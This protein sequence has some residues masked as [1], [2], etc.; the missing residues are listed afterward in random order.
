MKIY[1]AQFLVLIVFGTAAA[2]V[3]G[4]ESVDSI[5][6]GLGGL[7]PMAHCNAAVYLIEYEHS[8]GETFS[9]IG[10]GSG[11]NYRYN[12]GHYLEDG[13]LQGLDVG[14]RYY[15]DGGMQGLFM[16][17]S[18]G[19]WKGDWTFTQFQNTPSQWEG[20]ANSNSVRLNFELGDRISVHDTNVSIMPVA[21]LGKF[22]SS[23]SCEATAP[24]SRI[25][26]PCNQKSE[27][28]VYLFFGVTVG[29]AF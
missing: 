14:A 15:P 1:F 21:N 23:R 18:L 10:R 4:A 22:F 26:T 5:N 9:L 20:R 6:L 12:D 16:G 29:I 24:S 13:K 11:V 25:G 3:S 27:V 8:L 19:S 2:E 7:N 17:G 28:N